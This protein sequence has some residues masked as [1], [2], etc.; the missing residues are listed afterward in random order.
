MWE[1][2]GQK[3]PSFAVEP[4]PGQE[5]VWDYPRPPKI[6][7]DNRPVKVINDGLVIAHSTETIRICE[8]A[9][10]PTF[11]I[12]PEDINWTK[13]V[14]V[15]GSSFCEWK[16]RAKYWGLAE[17]QTHRPV[18]WSYESPSTRFL[19]IRSHVSFYPGLI[20][21]YV[22]GERVQPQPGEF[23][24]GWITSDVVG[25]FKGEPGTGHW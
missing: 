11:Y 3:R 17:D 20:A 16:G 21:C 12:P 25:P 5:S 14:P 8:T 7:A 1:Y 22:D 6:V 2:R 24:G 19:E 9:S 13:L 18:A 10:P 23:Y 15:P 4:R